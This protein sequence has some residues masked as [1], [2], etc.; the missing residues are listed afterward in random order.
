MAVL[1]YAMELLAMCFELVRQQPPLLFVYY[2]FIPCMIRPGFANECIIRTVQKIC[3][4]L[5]YCN[6]GRVYQAGTRQSNNII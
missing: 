5:E 4:Y 6:T 3:E 1:T 2:S